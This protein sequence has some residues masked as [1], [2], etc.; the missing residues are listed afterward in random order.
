MPVMASRQDLPSAGGKKANTE[1][2]ATMQKIG[3]LRKIVSDSLYE[4]VK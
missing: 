3:A 4:E 2:A 1:I